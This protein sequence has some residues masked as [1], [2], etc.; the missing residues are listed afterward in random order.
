MKI[1]NIKKKMNAGERAYGCT[2]AHSAPTYVEWAGMAGFDFV[3]LHCFGETNPEKL[4]E[5]DD[6]VAKYGDFKLLGMVRKKYRD[7]AKL[8]AY[9]SQLDKVELQ[10]G[11]APA[12]Q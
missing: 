3:Q 4:V 5:V 11:A 9:V 2:F 7:I 12:A 10:E 1:N 8:E 6:L